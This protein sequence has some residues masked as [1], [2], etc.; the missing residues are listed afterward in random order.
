M[1]AL[2]LRRGY[3]QTG[4]PWLENFGSCSSPDYYRAGMT[5]AQDIR[6]AI[7]YF[8]GRPE[9]QRDR[10]LLIGL[11]AG[12]WGSL[13]A[14]SQNP[15]GVFAV[16]NFAGGRGGGHPKVGNCAP[17]RLVDA[18]ARYGSTA[19]IPTLWLYAAN[20]SFF[21][22]DLAR[23]MSGA[24]IRAGGRAEYV[25][26][27]AFGSDGHR[28]FGA[29]DGRALWQP[30]VETFL[31]T[32]KHEDRSCRRRS[33]GR[34]LSGVASTGETSVIMDWHA[35]IYTPE[36]AA[37]D[38]GT[39]DGKHGPKWG[40]RG[41]PMVLENFLEAHYAN[42]I[43]ISVVT[44]AAHY[45]RGKADREE[46]AAVQKWTDYAADVQE[47]HKGTLYSFATILPCGG[48]AFLKEAERAIR[49]LGLKGI[50][51]HSSH[52]GHYPD[53]DEARPF[54][55]LVQELDVPVMIHPPHLGFGEERMKE[56]R[57]A[58]SIGRPFDLCLAL[59]R[60]IVR[61][62]LEDFPGVKIV[63]SHGGGGICETISRMDYAYELQDE[64]F[65][66]GSYA[67]MKIRHAPSH[68]LKRMYLDT[69]TYNLPAVKMVLEWMGP[70]RVIY[71]SDAPP[72]TS[73]KPRAI[74]LINDLDLPA[75]ERD[76][77]FW[78]NAARLLKLPLGRAAHAA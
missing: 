26:L 38:L 56:Y 48:P 71:G 13:A 61:G 4:G 40:E 21:A 42:G 75:A 3:G 2:P 69:V 59:G 12:G 14:A 64:A 17:R 8:R 63:A 68:Y 36:E 28:L 32:L 37:G 50:F 57:L 6:T 18:A 10:I 49:Q 29:A 43:D 73:L 22:P 35:H 45:L 41:C 53:D 16:I 1:V 66:L 74:K 44:N 5:T 62:I 34:R 51:I 30:R 33:G 23:K 11:S 31:E 27:P 67:P 19:R 58:S 55:A 9:V 54:W 60:L 15:A 77:I 46:L 24:F 39:L 7:D 65:F 20:D 76:A 52:K 47:K 70:D 72:L 25:A 78:A